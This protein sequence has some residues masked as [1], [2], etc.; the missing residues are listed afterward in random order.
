MWW[1]WRSHGKLP[2]AGGWLD[3][4]LA[5]LVKINAYDLIYNTF[6]SNEK[7][8]GYALDKLDATQLE[9]IS[10]IESDG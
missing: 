1:E 10:W 4:P 6:T 5:L 9:I 8:N 7:R 3:Q 2:K